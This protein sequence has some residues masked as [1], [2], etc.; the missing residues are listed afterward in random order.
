MSL[1]ISLRAPA[2][3]RRARSCRTFHLVQ[4]GRASRCRA[5]AV[6]RPDRRDGGARAAAA[7]RPRRRRDGD[8]RATRS[9]AAASRASS[10]LLQRQP[11]VEIVQNG[12]PGAT[13]GVFLRGANAAQTLVLVDGMRVASASSGA[14]RARGDPARPDR[15]DR[16]PARARVEPVRRRCDR[17]RDPGVHASADHGAT[18]A[19]ASI[20]Y[21]TLRHARRVGGRAGGIRVARGTPCRSP[22]GA[23]TASTRSSIRRT[24][25]TTRIATA[26][27][28][29][30]SARTASCSSRPVTRCSVQY[31]RS[32]LD[33]QFDARRCVRRSDDHDA[34][35]LAGALRRPLG[36][37]LA[38]ARSAR[39][40]RRR[41]VSQTGFGQAFR[42]DA[43]APVRVAE[44]R[45]T[46][47]RRADARARAARGA[48]RH[49]CRVRRRRAR[50]ERRTGVYRVAAGAHA[51]QA[52]V[53]HDDS[54]QFGGR[55]TGAFAYGYRIRARLARDR[56]RGHRVQGADV[57][58]SLFPGLLESRIC[59]RRR[60]AT[61]KPACTATRQ[62]RRTSRGRRACVAYHN[63]VRDLIVFQCD[64]EL[65]LRDRT[66]SPTRRSKGVTLGRQTRW[67]DTTLRR[68]DRR[69]VARPTTRPGHLL[70]RRARRHGG[71]VA[72]AAVRDAA[73]SSPSSSVVARA[74]TMRR[75]R[76]G[77]AVTRS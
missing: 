11:G 71:V 77:S 68:V 56:E 50:H 37:E 55:T 14:D 72:V 38:L 16:N 6:A 59:A 32:H 60:R 33:S 34:A 73:R 62:P 13:S 58:R 29:R 39:R 52:N 12:G 41:S 69:A 9:R 26:I 43:S 31:F 67:R 23:A 15:A 70:P 22:V 63:R 4:C 75:T 25:A 35:E 10:Q 48:R 54:S 65:R 24:S 27:A 40:R 74:S 28:T 20:G 66:T 3:A 47:G 46:A 8:R 45:R 76:V 57:Q 1:S 18:H 49:R 30:A 44:R 64:A 61:S 7:H 17:R 21:G 2:L 5:P 42:S 53:R 19:N 51:L 36:R